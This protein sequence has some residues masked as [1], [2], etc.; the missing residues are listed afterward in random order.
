VKLLGE[1]SIGAGVRR[2]EALVGVDAYSFLA[3]EHILLNSITELIKGSRPEELPEKISQLLARLKEIEKELGQAKT[4]QALKDSA[5]LLSQAELIGG[6]SVI[7]HNM[8]QDLSG[9]DLRVVA[10]DLRSK[11]PNSVIALSSAGAEK[12]VLV[13]AVDETARGGG[14]KA[15]AL[16]K[17]ASGILGGGGGGKDDFA[18]GGG[19]NA[20][21]IPAALQAI[22]ESLRK[23]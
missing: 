14:V 2:V 12:V 20:A 13:V 22:K 18:Q 15:G 3:R 9:D 8:P 4:Q 11:L 21:A 1:S 5:S 19:V 23:S 10:L 6:V 7:A 16:V 17:T